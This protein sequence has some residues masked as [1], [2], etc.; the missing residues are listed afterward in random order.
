MPRLR[1]LKLRI[2]V[3]KLEKGL[4]VPVYRS[5]KRKRRMIPGR[6]QQ[7]PSLALQA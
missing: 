1:S 4:K 6:C 2:L 5:L 7:A 3:F